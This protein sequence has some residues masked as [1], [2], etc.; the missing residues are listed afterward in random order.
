M[1]KYLRYILFLS[2]SMAFCGCGD[3]VE[4]EPQLPASSSVYYVRYEAVVKSIYMGDNIKYSVTTADGLKV[5]VSGKSFSQTFG[6]VEKGFNTA[7]TADAS[8]WSQAVC[9]VKIY[10]SRDNEPFALKANAS[11][12]KKASTHYVIDY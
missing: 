7:I 3:D 10:V 12:E 5:F 6:P 11:G 8:S 2:L 9:N 1:Y 4:D